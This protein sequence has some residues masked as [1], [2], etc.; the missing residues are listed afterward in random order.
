MSASMRRAGHARGRASALS[1]PVTM[2]YRYQLVDL[3]GR[4]VDELE[5]SARYGP[6]RSFS[7]AAEAGASSRSSA[8]RRPSPRCDAGR[9][10]KTSS[11]RYDGLSTTACELGTGV[12]GPPPRHSG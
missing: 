1:Q 8:A 5:R 12:R 9:T 3:A 7:S 10:A 6:T 4:E 11:R 2:A